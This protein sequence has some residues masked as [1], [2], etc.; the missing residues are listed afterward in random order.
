MSLNPPR[1]LT[2]F[3][4]FH[5]RFF[6][7]WENLIILDV[8]DVVYATNAWTVSHSQL[9][10]IIRSTALTTTTV[11]LL[12]NVPVVAKVNLNTVIWRENNLNSNFS[13]N[14][15]SWRNRGNCTCSFYG[16]RFPC[17]L[18]RLRRMRNATD[19]WTGQ[20]MLSIGWATSLSTLSYSKSNPSKFTQL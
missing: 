1:D 7:L 2:F 12:P 20:K 17:G 4:N 18:L 10:L 11:C 15:T 6:K 3:H 14:N 5:S 9:T 8:S 16:Q 13:R 19:R